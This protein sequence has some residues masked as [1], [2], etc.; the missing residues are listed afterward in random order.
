VR[1]EVPT[2]PETR[3]DITQRAIVVDAERRTMLLK[4]LIETQHPDDRVLVFAA[5]KYATE[6]VAHKLARAGLKAAAFHGELSQGT[7]RATLAA[8][9]ASELQVVIATDVAARGIDIARLPVVVNYDL[10]RAPA[11]HVHRI[12]RTG[13]AGESGT[14]YSFITPDMEGHFRLIEKRQGLRV[15][16]ERIE[17]FEPQGADSEGGHHPDDLEAG[18][19]AEEQQGVHVPGTGGIKGKRKSKKDKLREAAARSGS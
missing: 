18:A 9:K 16:R 19:T 17:G 5:T 11:D 8:F 10:P 3:P 12:G 15:P 6:L 1:V 7:R 4:H 13:R 2:E 14:A